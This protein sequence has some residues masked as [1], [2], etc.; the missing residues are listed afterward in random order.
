MY[1]LWDRHC[2]GYLSRHTI[3]GPHDFP[4][5]GGG[6]IIGTRKGLLCLLTATQHPRE[7]IINLCLGLRLAP[8]TAHAPSHAKLSLCGGLS[9]YLG[10][11]LLSRARL[12]ISQVKPTPPSKRG[13][14]RRSSDTGQALLLAFTVTLGE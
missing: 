6:T 10:S 7:S 13:P 4:C 12:P 3:S 2:A 9:I 8:F 14:Q 11:A 5:E 1:P